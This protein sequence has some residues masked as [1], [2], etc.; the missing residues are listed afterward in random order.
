MIASLAS[1]DNS[2]NFPGKGLKRLTLRLGVL[3]VGIG[4]LYIQKKNIRFSKIFYTF[5]IFQHINNNKGIIER[6][7]TE[8]PCQLRTV[9]FKNIFFRTFSYTNFAVKI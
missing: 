3:Q 4:H 7:T 2:A 9:A 6:N 1:L 5:L 8:Y